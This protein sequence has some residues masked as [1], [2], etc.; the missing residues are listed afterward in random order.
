L[1][2]CASRI[3][4][5][6]AGNHNHVPVQGLIKQGAKFPEA[7]DESPEESSRFVPVNR[8]LGSIQR[9]EEADAILKEMRDAIQYVPEDELMD[10][11]KRR[12]SLDKEKGDPAPGPPGNQL[13]SD[14]FSDRECPADR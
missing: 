4:N 11:S 10:T 12:L 8:I 2:C 9:P 1:R 7:P 13:F 6:R 14:I 3:C 5:C